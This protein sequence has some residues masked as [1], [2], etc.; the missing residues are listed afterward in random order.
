MILIVLPPF[1][2]SALSANDP[3]QRAADEGITT[4]TMKTP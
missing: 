3:S 2:C 1:V 4:V